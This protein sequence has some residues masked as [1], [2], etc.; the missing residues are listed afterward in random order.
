VE[1]RR[2][3]PPLHRTRWIGMAK[4]HGPQIKDDTLY[5]DL[6]K[7]GASKEKAAR[8][9]NA[10]AAGTLK[11]DSTHLEDRTVRQLQDEAKEIGIAG[12]S[13]MKKDALVEAIR[14]HK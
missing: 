7:Q 11:H 10:K 13:R 3:Q 14:S 6:R 2:A 5:E 9:A 1:D 4:D 8:I 12:R